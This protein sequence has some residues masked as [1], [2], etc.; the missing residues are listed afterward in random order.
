MKAARNTLRPVLISSVLNQ[1]ALVWVKTTL[2]DRSMFIRAAYIPP[3]AEISTY[4][5]CC[6]ETEMSLSSMKQR[7]DAI[8]LGDFNIP[9]ISW[10]E[11]T[12]LPGTCIPADLS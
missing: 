4:E 3:G 8:F 5:A 6:D 10:V 2:K 9:D 7:D 11:D 12:D 1:T